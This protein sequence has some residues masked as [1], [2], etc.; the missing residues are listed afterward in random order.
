VIKET[1]RIFRAV[2]MV[3]GVA[4]MVACGDDET[5]ISPTLP[6]PVTIT[7]TFTGTINKNGAASHNFIA[8]TVGTVTAT[9]KTI[10]PD[11]E[12]VVG[13]GIGTWNGTVCNVILARDRAV[14]STVIYGNVNASGELCVRVYDV[15]SVV[16]TA[17]YTVEV[18]HP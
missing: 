15:G 2:V 17:D 11:A 14:Q 4:A 3:V 13:F 1:S 18:I 8:T 7:D 10:A 5:P 12:M 9:L 16:D 6:T